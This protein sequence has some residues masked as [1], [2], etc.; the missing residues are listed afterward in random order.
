MNVTQN[1]QSQA[2][3]EVKIKWPSLDAIVTVKMNDLNPTLV[4]LFG[5]A[6][7]YRSL[8]THAVVAGDQLYH[9]VPLEQLIYTPADN[10]APDRAKE[11]DGSVFLSSFQ[12]LVIKYGEVTEHQSVAT[13]GKVI[14]EDL[15]TLHWVADKI[16]Q[17]QCD[18][19]QPIEVVLWDASKP[20]PDPKSIPLFAS[21]RTGVSKEVKN[22]VDEIYKETEKS[23]SS[24]SEGIEKLHHGQA[25]EK[26]GSKNSYLGAMI[27]SSS[28]VRTLGYHIFDN[29]IKLAATRP[30]FTLQH[31]II[32]FRDLI[33]SISEFIGHL[34]VEFLCDSYW[35]ADKLVKE[36]VES[37]PNQ[38]EAREDFL[39]MI[40]ALAFYVNLLNAQNLHMFPWRHTGEYQIP[41]K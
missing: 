22:L 38:E 6:L 10:K 34:G 29:I 17:S 24:I 37:N 33:P 27:F 41:T 31:L 3:R 21:Q 16:W 30:E 12:H 7:P 39:A 9:L 28:V 4:G 40:S 1:Q 25:R 15:E 20:E 14:D 19:K 35:K 5:N 32:L 18:T 8:Q 36:K 26:P 23:W 2:P 11:P 13:C